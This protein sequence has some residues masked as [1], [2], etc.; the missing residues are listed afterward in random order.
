M[1]KQNFRHLCG[2][3]TCTASTMVD[4]CKST[5]FLVRCYT[6]ARVGHTANDSKS[7]AFDCVMR[8]NSGFFCREWFKSDEERQYLQRQLRKKERQRRKQLRDERKV[9]RRS[10]KEEVSE[11]RK[12]GRVG[13]EK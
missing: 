5:R 6:V 8:D 1:H 10:V 9:H 11:D 7:R 12:S 13:K 3:L 4:V 2:C